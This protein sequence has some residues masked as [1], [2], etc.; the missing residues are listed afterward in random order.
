MNTDIK[1]FYDTYLKQLGWREKL[2]LIELLMH[3][4]LELVHEEKEL[5]SSAQ[6][7]EK[8]LLGTTEKEPHTDLQKKL[9]GG[10]VMEE[11]DYLLYEEKKQHFAQWK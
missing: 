9:L 2:E 6:K 5:S 7:T 4:T 3:A 10:P 8:Q 11:K 1:E